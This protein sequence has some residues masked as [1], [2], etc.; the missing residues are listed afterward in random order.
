MHPA[1]S[2]LMLRRNVRFSQ[3]RFAKLTGH[4]TADSVALNEA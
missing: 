3:L 2:D 4:E 1:V